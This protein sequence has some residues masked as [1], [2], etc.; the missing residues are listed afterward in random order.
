MERLDTFID[1]RLKLKQN[2][3]FLKRGEREAHEFDY[4]VMIRTMHL[5]R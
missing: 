2:I 4:F 5:W 3:F 1:D